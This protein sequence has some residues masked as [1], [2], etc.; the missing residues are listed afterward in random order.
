MTTMSTAQRSSAPTKRRYATLFIFLALASI[1]AS[2]IPGHSSA[3]W[4]L[5]ALGFVLFVTALVVAI[6]EMRKARRENAGKT[7]RS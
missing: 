4:A 6:I 3:A 5:W 7:S 2:L 1:M